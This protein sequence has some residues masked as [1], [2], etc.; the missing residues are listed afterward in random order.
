MGTSIR[1]WE[2]FLEIL[3]FYQIEKVIDVQS[4]PTSRFPQLIQ[5]EMK[6]NL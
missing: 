2:K 5:E 1:S 4:F 6:K 3:R